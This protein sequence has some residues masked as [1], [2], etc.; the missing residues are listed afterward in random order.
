[1]E[2]LHKEEW[3]TMFIIDSLRLVA[4]RW[5]MNENQWES[6]VVKDARKLKN[7]LP[8]SIVFIHHNHKWWWTFSWSQD[9]ENFVDWR[10]EVKRLNDP[11]ANWVTIFN[12][13]QIRI[14]KERLWKELEFLFN[15]DKWNLIFQSTNFIK[16]EKD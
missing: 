13:T 7:R 1:M 8:I 12:Q 4:W 16:Y 5:N 6:K 3:Y 2:K 15:Y 11:D 14:Y 10:I 9:L